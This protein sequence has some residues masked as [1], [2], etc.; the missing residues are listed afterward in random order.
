MIYHARLNRLDDKFSIIS[1]H[2]LINM[3]LTLPSPFWGE[4]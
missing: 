3:P 2:N 4:D 1:V